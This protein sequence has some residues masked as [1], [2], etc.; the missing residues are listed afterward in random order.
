MKAFFF[1][2]LSLFLVVL[3]L[4]G[5][6]N[7]LYRNNPLDPTAPGSDVTSFSSENESPKETVA[8]SSIELVINE[9]S[10]GQAI[11]DENHIIYFTTIG[12]SLKSLS[13]ETKE[14]ETI[15][16]SL[17]GTPIEAVWA[18][19]KDK[20]LLLLENGGL[21]RWHL[22]RLDD[23]SVLPLKENVKYP[24][25]S[26]LG[27]RIFY[28][29]NDPKTG[30]VTLNAANPDGSNW[31]A[32]VDIPTKN[33]FIAAIPKSVDVSLWNRPN[34]NETS[35]FQSIPGSGGELKN[36][37]TGKYGGDYLWS[38][39]GN[40][41]LVSSLKEKGGSKIFLA[42]I[43][44]N[45]GEFTNL[46]VRTL[47]SKAVWSKDEKTIY[48]ALPGSLPDNITLPND[49]FAKKLETA[50]TF[51]KVNVETGEKNRLVETTDIG[52][53]FDSMNLFLSERE[54]VL[55]F[56]NRRDGRTYSIE[57]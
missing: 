38:P 56:L 53:E 45:G 2:S 42:I 44:R 31:K 12:K 48:Y 20:A 21:S 34:G 47:V 54:D 14:S 25:F 23:R 36:I 28:Q 55:Y 29:F 4:F 19:G 52:S 46:D 7:F 11:T 10:I 22:V 5:A 37:L 1:I 24:T 49:Y 30:D 40:K 6:Y 16:D 35:Y 17:P 15:I 51:W 8:P 41:V 3:V 13:L 39:N 32:L 27:D 43:N 26:N 9:K 50:D 18:K 57:L 33:I